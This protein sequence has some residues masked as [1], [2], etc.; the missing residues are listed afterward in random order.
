M[1]MER[2]G[3]RELKGREENYASDGSLMM[4]PGGEGGQDAQWS[5]GVDS[6]IDSKE[7]GRERKDV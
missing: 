2:K 7:K 1:K 6:S 5:R 4:Q 3:G